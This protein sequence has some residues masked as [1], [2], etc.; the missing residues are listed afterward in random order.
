MAV[1][2]PTFFVSKADLSLWMFL[3]NVGITGM[4]PN[5]FCF[6]GGELLLCSLGWL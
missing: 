3:L 2:P 4:N 6:E 5:N 1:V